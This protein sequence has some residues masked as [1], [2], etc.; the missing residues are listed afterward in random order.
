MSEGEKPTEQDVTL[1]TKE[2]ADD[3][4]AASE[5][6][7]PASD[8]SGSSI[9]IAPSVPAHSK[10]AT[11]PG[12]TLSS[13]A[14]APQASTEMSGPAPGASKKLSETTAA[15]YGNRAAEQASDYIHKQPLFALAITC[16]VCLAIGAMLGRR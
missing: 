2:A 15:E 14:H 4:M 5:P 3:I 8:K 11:T 16:V 7:E 1:W 6:R 13:S 10:A 9:G 12:Q